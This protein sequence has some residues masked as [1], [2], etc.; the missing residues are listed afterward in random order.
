MSSG[1]YH[2]HVAGNVWHSTGAGARDLNRAGLAWFSLIANDVPALR[3]RLEAAHVPLSATAKG[4]DTA[5]PW[6]TPLRIRSREQSP[7]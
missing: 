5:D 3:A 2:H 7:G 1:H 4:L 6:G